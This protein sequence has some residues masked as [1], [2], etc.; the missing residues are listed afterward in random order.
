MKF[1]II[2]TICLV[3]TSLLSYGQQYILFE[4]Q[5][6]L[7]QKKLTTNIFLSQNESKLKSNDTTLFIFNYY[8]SS[9]TSGNPPLNIKQLE[10]NNQNLQFLGNDVLITAVPLI[11][12]GDQL[13]LT[14]ITSKD[15]SMLDLFSQ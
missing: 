1:K 9:D 11:K 14:R 5:I 7:N 8:F 13:K 4:R 3:T 15:F 6:T 12:P 2:T 10:K